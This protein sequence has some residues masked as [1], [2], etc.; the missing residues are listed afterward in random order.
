MYGKEDDQW[1]KG[2]S[3][4]QGLPIPIPRDFMGMAAYE[5]GYSTS[6]INPERLEFYDY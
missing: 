3:I 6:Y 1:R 2:W 5:G 4:G